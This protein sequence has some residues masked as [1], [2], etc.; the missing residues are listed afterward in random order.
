MGGKKKSKKRP[1]PK[2]VL[3]EDE[4][5][6]ITSLIESLGT[7]EPADIVDRVP[8]ARIAKALVDRLPL[9]DPSII[10]LLTALKSG[11]HD[12]HLS[13]AVNRALFRLKAKGIAV[14]EA[15]GQKESASPI[16]KSLPKDKPT[17]YI[18]PVDGAGT[19]LVMAILPRASKGVDVGIGIV[20]DELGILQFMS[21]T[22][23]KKR[24]KEIKESSAQNAGPLVESSLSHA[25]SILEHAYNRHPEAHEAQSGYL[26]I[27]QRLL[28][29]GSIL[30]RSPV[31]DLIS[32]E[33]L[34]GE[35]LANTDLKTL[36]DHELMKSWFVDFEELRPFMEELVNTEESPL[37]L[38]ETQKLDRARE[39]EQKALEELFPPPRQ[40]L[41]KR[42]L[43]EMAYVYFE[44][45][46][47]KYAELCLVAAG[48][49]DMKDASVIRK[50]VVCEFLLKRSLN[51]YMEQAA[52]GTSG[53]KE[54]EKDVSS[55]LILP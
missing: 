32:E 27:R 44:L 38:T 52:E 51:Y 46:Q 4:E 37:F 5:L 47:K 39:I 14:E 2:T 40:V 41:L 45:D 36:F 24:V 42:R 11:F 50:S 3:S 20:S 13:K 35:T 6:L 12:K 16:L 48:A 26:D 55:P 10:S 53:I 23:S 18:G 8:D 29:S 33:S 7:H 9:K 19:R 49:T 54:D 31:Y 25:V 30:E 28:K 21:G 43:E 17:S 34:S 15:S 22:F 1:P